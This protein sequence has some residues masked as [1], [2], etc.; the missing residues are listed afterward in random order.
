ME[1]TGLLLPAELGAGEGL[2]CAHFWSVSALNSFLVPALY[3]LLVRVFLVRLHCPNFR[4]VFCL[5]GLT[6][7]LGKGSQKLW[8]VKPTLRN[9]FPTKAVRPSVKFY[10][11][12]LTFIK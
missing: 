5:P 3:S 12:S 9:I 4:S 7:V 11:T 8:A 2:H 1:N 6:S 10:Q